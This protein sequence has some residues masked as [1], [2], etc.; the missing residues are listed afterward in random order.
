MLGDA[1]R[2]ELI[3]PN[4]GSESF[5]TAYLDEHGPGLHHVTIEVANLDEAT[6]TLE[7]A[8]V[9]VVDRADLNDYSEA[10]LSPRNPTGSLL[11]L[12][13]YHE[14]YATRR[15]STEGLFVGGEPLEE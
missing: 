15:E 1:S 5:L 14:T 3:A 10:F 12:M 4:E 2:I 8:G 9:R 11:Q 6:A 13:E 7:A